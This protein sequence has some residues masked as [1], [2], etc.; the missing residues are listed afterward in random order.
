VGA[1]KEQ[2]GRAEAGADECA[3]PVPLT[4]PHATGPAEE[5]EQDDAYHMPS[6]YEDA[7]GR[8]AKYEVLT[9]RYR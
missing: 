3:P 7:K 4:V 5:L 6:G 8:S 9:Q 1:G 2:P